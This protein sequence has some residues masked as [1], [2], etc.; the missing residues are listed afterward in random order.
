MKKATLFFV[1]MLL[2]VLTFAQS[3]VILV[4]GS[5]N[6]TN[7]CSWNGTPGSGDY[8]NIQLSNPSV[9]SWRFYYKPASGCPFFSNTSATGPYIV[10]GSSG[11]YVFTAF[12]NVSS[13]CIAGGCSTYWGNV[14]ICAVNAITN[15]VLSCKTIYINP[16]AGYPVTGPSSFRGSAQFSTTNPTPN[17]QI[18]DAF[19]YSLVSTWTNPTT[20]AAYTHTPLNS[21]VQITS[22]TF[23]SRNILTTNRDP[24]I[25]VSTSSY[26]FCVATVDVADH[27]NANYPNAPSW[28]GLKHFTYNWLYNGSS[29]GTT[30][31]YNYSAMPSGATLQCEVKQ[32]QW[33]GSAWVLETQEMSNTMLFSGSASCG[34]GIRINGK[35]PKELPSAVS[36]SP[37]PFKEE[38]TLKMNLENGGDCSLELYDLGGRL[39]SA[40]FKNRKFDSGNNVAVINTASLAPG[41]Y[42]YK[43]KMN[44]QV[45]TGKIIKE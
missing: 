3:N 24:L 31:N 20:V 43:L 2:S 19:N 9:G 45:H 41:M 27:A 1:F 38:F 22:S 14:T 17:W 44:D 40:G 32:Y 36:I 34:G 11:Y 23:C 35:L 37:S 8:L 18:S 13:Q 26:P 25:Y 21:P 16:A 29:V 6:P 5:A 30:Q 33:N 10:N 15:A 28:A 4:N 7:I 12:G 42:I 39:M